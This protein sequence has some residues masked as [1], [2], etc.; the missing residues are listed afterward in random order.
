[1]GNEQI[2][3][4]Q[5]QPALPWYFKTSMIVIVFLCVGPLALPMVWFHPR[6]KL[7][8]KIWVTVLII[9]VT[10]YSVVAMGSSLK[11]LMRL[12]HELMGN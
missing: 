4:R 11:L 7:F 2:D 1:M 3:N 6:Y 5:E 12:Y 8:T 9:A 10:Y